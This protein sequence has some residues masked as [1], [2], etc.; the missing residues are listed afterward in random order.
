M[1]TGV[2]AAD[3]NGD[4][5]MDL[6]VPIEAGPNGL[7]LVLVLL[8]QGDGTFAAPTSY[9]TG[10]DPSSVAVGDLNGDRIPDLAV[11]N[12]LGSSVSIFLGKS[13]G[14]LELLDSVQVNGNPVDVKLVDVNG[15]GKLDLILPSQLTNNVS[16]LLNR[17]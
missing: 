14:G 3:I 15:D 4:G 9:G 5:R 13:G 2:T 16:I 10:V 8:G 12:R 17:L 1:P 6:A 7:G 11:A